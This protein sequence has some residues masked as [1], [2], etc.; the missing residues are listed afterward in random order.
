[1]KEEKEEKRKLQIEQKPFS[2]R[3]LFVI[4]LIFHS[5]YI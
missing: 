5:R 4:I 2:P 3:A 1:M